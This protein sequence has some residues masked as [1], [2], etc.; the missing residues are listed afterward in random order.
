MGYDDGTGEHYYDHEYS[1]TSDLMNLTHESN[2]GIPRYWAFNL[3]EKIGKS[4]L[5]STELSH[6]L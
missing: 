1:R 5:I 6:L 2:I 4:T 3:T